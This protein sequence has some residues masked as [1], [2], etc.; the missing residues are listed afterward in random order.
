[1]SSFPSAQLQMQPSR[2]ACK[3]S[4]SGAE[5]ILCSG[6]GQT[7]RAEQLAEV[8]DESA[9]G[10]K[11]YRTEEQISRTL[12]PVNILASEEQ[13]AKKKSKWFSGKS[14]RVVTVISMRSPQRVVTTYTSE[15]KS[16]GNGLALKAGRFG[17]GSNESV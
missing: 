10:G 17:C 6:R 4:Q 8:G 16:L 11:M 2:R 3:V 7:K 13:S 12:R 15:N 14:K 9:G 1:M 5:N